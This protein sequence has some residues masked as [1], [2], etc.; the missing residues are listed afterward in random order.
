M[1]NLGN[2]RDRAFDYGRRNSGGRDHDRDHDRRGRYRPSYSSFYQ[3]EIV[4][5][6]GYW[7]WWGSDYSGYSDDSGYDDSAANQNYA[8][9]GAENGAGDG[10]DSP[11]P[12]EEQALARAYR[13]S[14]ELTHPSPAPE[15]EEAVTL[16]FKDGRPSEQ[17]HNY[18]LSRDTLS[19]LDKQRR[20]IPVEQ[21]DVAATEKVNREAG[22][23]FHLPSAGR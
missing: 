8:G 20:D 1:R 13:P 22:V 6:G 5:G 15:R 14:A 2:Y 16:V 10:Y 19:V 3:P 7:P 17:I 18:L 9:N 11:P 4:Y 21:L 23:D 12:P